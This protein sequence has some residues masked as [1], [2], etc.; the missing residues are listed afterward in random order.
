MDGLRRYEE[1]YGISFW[2]DYV[3]EEKRNGERYLGNC[4]RIH[5][6]SAFSPVGILGEILVLFS[7]RFRM[8]ELTV[9]DWED[10]AE[11]LNRVFRFFKAT[12]IGSFN[13]SLFSGSG[14]GARSWVYARLCPRIIIP[15]WDTSDINYFERLHD[16]VICVIPPEEMFKNLKPYFAGRG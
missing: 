13:L 15:P 7:D 5:F 2:E 10:L 4:G 14:E 8:K 9:T 3:V 6:L 16:E 12:H 11:G 1:Q